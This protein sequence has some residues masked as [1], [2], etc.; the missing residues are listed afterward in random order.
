MRLT[1]GW[2][3]VAAGAVVAPFVL[4]ACYGLPPC[5]TVD[6]DGDGFRTCE[7]G[8]GGG[9]NDDCDDTDPNINPGQEEVCDDGIDN[10]CDGISSSTDQ[11]E[12]CGN[13]LDD[14]CDGEVD[15]LAAE[16]GVEVECGD[17]FDDDCDGLIDF[18]DPDCDADVD[19]EMDSDSDSVGAD[20][21]DIALAV[22]F[23][24]LDSGVDCATAG[25]TT[26][27]VSVDGPEPVSAFDV[28]CTDADVVVAQLRSGA[29]TVAVQ[30]QSTDGARTWG[31]QPV[32]VDV[33]N[34]QTASALVVLTCTQSG[35]DDPC[36]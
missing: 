29:W 17:G 26:L 19:T 7:D 28:A 8:F 5:E 15:E 34:A 35:T 21:G 36:D 1:A 30:A 3:T 32:A 25:V 23:D 16:P 33:Q 4:S 6:R 14:D 24:G 11:P 9:W 31:A 27:Q 22:H 20:A 13:G 12:V 10:N 18:D 2:L